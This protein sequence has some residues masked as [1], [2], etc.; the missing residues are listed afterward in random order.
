[1]HFFN[2]RKA[3]GKISILRFIDWLLSLGASCC[4]FLVIFTGIL[5][6]GSSACSALTPEQVV[7]VANKMAW[8]SC[9]LAEYYMKKRGIPVD[10]LIE[11]KAPGGEHCSRDDYEQYIAAPIRAFV[12][13]NDPKGDRFHCLVTMYG[14]PLRVDSPELTSED[15]KCLSGLQKQQDVIREQIDK[16]EREQNKKELTALK[17]AEAQLKRQIDQARKALQGAA[18]DSELALVREEHYPLDYWVPNKYFVG[19]RGQKIDNM[20]QNVLVVSRLDGPSEDVVRRIIDDS[21]QAEKEG[22]RGTA[23]FDARWPDPGDKK[24]TGYAFYDRA[25]HN[26]S[27]VVKGSNLMPVVLDSQQKLFEPGQS[28]NAALYCGW[29]SL[30]HYVDAFTWARGAVGFH[31]ASAECTTLKGKGSKV[32]CKVMLEKGVAATLGPVGEPYVQAFPPPDLFFA[33]L[34]DGR[35]T[36]AECYALS[37]PFWSWQMVLIGDPLYRPFKNSRSLF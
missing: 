25:I 17:D 5:L 9:D 28:P 18:V 35:L 14:I 22:L 11:L 19:Y 30:A 27:R 37:N 2:M 34:I 20:P 6:P 24:I 33:L 21:L 7:V 15:Q 36:L 16:A 26:A 31:I 23:Y 3:K 8:H 1:M 29:Y 12:K 10:N 4:G 13:K 32:W